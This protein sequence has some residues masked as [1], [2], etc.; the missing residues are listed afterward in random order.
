MVDIRLSKLEQLAQY[1]SLIDFYKGP[2]A[3]A[4]SQRSVQITVSMIPH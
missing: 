3:V 2:A 4:E 1:N